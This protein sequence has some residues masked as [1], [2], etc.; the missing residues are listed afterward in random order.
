MNYRTLRLAISNLCPDAEYTVDEGDLDKLTWI[1][2]SN[3]PTKSEIIAEMINVEA[4]EAQAEL[5]ATA[6]KQAL[7]DKL[8]IT[9]DEAKLLL[10]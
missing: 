1:V 4:S 7:L 2:A 9:E 10:S 3:P 6:K 5:E 8:G